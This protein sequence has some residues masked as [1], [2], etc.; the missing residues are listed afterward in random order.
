M[1]NASK[2]LIMAGGVLIAI[3]IIALLYSFITTLSAKAEEED[4]LLLAEQTETF[5][6]E[7]EAFEKKLLRGTDLITVM[8]KA[9]ANNEKYD[10]QD[11][12]YDVEV[13]FKLKTAV[14][15]VTVEYVNGKQKATKE[16]VEFDADKEYSLIEDKAQISKFMDFGLQQTVDSY[17]IIDYEDKRNYK[18]VYDNYVVFKRKLFSCTKIGYSNET[19]RVNLLVF[20]EIMASG[21]ELEGYN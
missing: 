12:V 16:E 14:S 18:K 8:N 13:K 1:E 4:L 21:G 10:D 20:E 5:N 9:A 7:Y 2:A 15:K 17:T 11:H 3:I 19:G 6:R